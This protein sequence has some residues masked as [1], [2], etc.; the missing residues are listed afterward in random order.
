M[1]ARAFWLLVMSFLLGCVNVDFDTYC[2]LHP[3]SCGVVSTDAADDT[4]GDT[5]AADTGADALLADT[6][7][8]DG[9]AFEGAPDV[10]AD[11]VDDV[12][13]EASTDGSS[14]VVAEVETGPTLPY[15]GTSKCAPSPLDAGFPH[16]KV[17][18]E[19]ADGVP[20][21][22]VAFS[23]N[24]GA[25]LWSYTLPTDSTQLKKL[26]RDAL[27][28]VWALT[29]GPTIVH[30]VASVD[31][32]VDQVFTLPGQPL[33][34]ASDGKTVWFSF[35]GGGS[36]PSGVWEY[37]V[38]TMT[39]LH[40]YSLSGATK[41][42]FDEADNQTFVLVP[43]TSVLRIGAG[44]SSL[45]SLGNYTDVCAG[46]GYLFLLDAASLKVGT[47]NVLDTSK[48]ATITLAKTIASFV[49]CAFDPYPAD[50]RLLVL[51]NLPDGSS[52]LETML[53]APAAWLQH[54]SPKAWAFDGYGATGW[55]DDT[56]K[57]WG[58]DS[59]LAPAASLLTNDRFAPV[60]VTP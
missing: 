3:G 21:T 31:C 15:V 6:S 24:T 12:I 52:D 35:K 47:V 56:G 26:R 28:N 37:D 27:G 9:P 1:S 44:T 49:S 16:D 53:T 45:I 41:I 59:D 32:N 51:A 55:V 23:A 17:F 14:D 29:D 33:D 40:T 10:S 11:V 46:Q 30:I 2:E 20:T 25:T 19:I 38:K 50:P 7:S 60:A 42:A 8:Q 4:S 22:V 39:L 13:A 34:V 18:T 43:G 36:V 5:A 58:I 54:W 57:A 48:T